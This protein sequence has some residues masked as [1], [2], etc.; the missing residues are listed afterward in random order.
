MHGIPFVHRDCY[1]RNVLVR[2]EGEE[3]DIWWLDCRRG[4]ARGRGGPL[5]DL[6]TLDRDLRGRLTRGER[7]A[8]LAAYLD[9]GDARE[10]VR[11]L[12]VRRDRLPPPR[13]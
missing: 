1:A 9:G 4:G 8:A 12:A 10:F 2:H 7:R 11:R 5:G 3:V 6:A 13:L